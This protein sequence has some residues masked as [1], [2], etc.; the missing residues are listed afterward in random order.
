MKQHR[1]TWQRHEQRIARA[2]GVERNGPTGTAT[3]DVTTP[4]LSVECKSWRTLPAKVVAALEQAEAAATPDQ[5]AL[6]V[7][8]Q[9]GA[10]SERD[11]VCLRWGDFLNWFGD[12]KQPEGEGVP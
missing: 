9:V 5:L 11:I 2:L 1:R 10:R 8:H 7:L 6:A 12:G 4:W 3:A